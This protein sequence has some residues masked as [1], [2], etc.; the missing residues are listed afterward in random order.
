MRTEKHISEFQVKSEI[1]EL[2]HFKK[3]IEKSS[4]LLICDIFRPRQKIIF[5]ELHFYLYPSIPY[6][7]N[8]ILTNIIHQIYHDYFTTTHTVLSTIQKRIRHK[9]KIFA[10]FQRICL[11]FPISL[12][13]SSSDLAVSE[14]SFEIQNKILN[15]RFLTLS[16]H[17]CAIILFLLTPK[18]RYF[19]SKKQTE[20]IFTK[21]VT[22]RQ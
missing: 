10:F 8:Y 1:S 5:L 19:D 7:H 17:N 21:I 2:L 11:C 14:F 3:L 12:F 18:P 4:I 20:I 9:N 15:S 6:L 22:R 13:I 16:A